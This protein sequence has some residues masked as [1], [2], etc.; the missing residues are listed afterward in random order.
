MA[1]PMSIRSAARSAAPGAGA[2]SPV[3]P[4]HPFAQAAMQGAQRP[5]PPPARPEPAR[6]RPRVVAPEPV[7]VGNAA[8]AVRDAPLA[9][10]PTPTRA[11]VIAGAEEA[12]VF[13]LPTELARRLDAARGPMGR[14]D[15]VGAIMTALLKGTARIAH[16]PA[17]EPSARAPIGAADARDLAQDLV[18]PQPDEPTAPFPPADARPIGGRPVI[19]PAATGKLGPI[20]RLGRGRVA[21][22]L[23]LLLTLGLGVSAALA[24]RQASRLEVQ[25]AAISALEDGRLAD[26]QLM[27]GLRSESD[28]LLLRNRAMERELAVLRGRLQGDLDSQR[29]ARSNAAGTP[30]KE[31]AATSTSEA[32]DRRAVPPPPKR[33]PVPKKE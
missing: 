27:A 24:L 19:R 4:A 12:I 30:A 25:A 5:S 14:S 31:T 16:V 23:M 7:V 6:V 10:A 8:A 33:K 2:A 1:Q 15:A 26:R 22:A 9:Q 11:P 13:S 20:D 3:L 18:D 21:A 17:D 28:Q 32:G 29:A